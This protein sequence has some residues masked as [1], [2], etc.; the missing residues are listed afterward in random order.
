MH[1]KF[2]ENSSLKLHT[3]CD[4]FTRFQPDLGGFYRMASQAHDM[5][6]SSNE[7]FRRMAQEHAQYSQRLES[8][9]SKRFLSEDEKIEEVRLKKLKLRLKDQMEQVERQFKTKNEVA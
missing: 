2:D 6:M 5:L 7:E 8:L 9:S 3:P 4:S 1:E